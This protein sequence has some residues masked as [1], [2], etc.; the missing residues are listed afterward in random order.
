MKGDYKCKYEL[1]AVPQSNLTDRSITSQVRY[2]GLL[3]ETL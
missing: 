3:E 2:G 1:C